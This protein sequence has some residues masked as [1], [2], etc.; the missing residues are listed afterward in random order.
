MNISEAFASVQFPRLEME[1][2]KAF[3]R[4]WGYYANQQTQRT[5]RWIVPLL[6]VLI[7]MMLWLIHCLVPEFGW[8]EILAL[9]IFVV[10]FFF[11]TRQF[12]L[13]QSLA[14]GHDGVCV[15]IHREGVAWD[16]EAMFSLMKWEQ[17]CGVFETEDQLLFIM[18]QARFSAAPKRFFDSE[19]DYM[20]FREAVTEFAEIQPCTANERKQVLRSPAQPEKKSGRIVLIIIWLLLIAILVTWFIAPWRDSLILSEELGE[21][22]YLR[23]QIG[24]PGVD[25]A[26][27]IAVHGYGSGPELMQLLFRRHTDF[28]LTVYFP[29]GPYWHFLGAKWD[30]WNGDD[31]AE[32]AREY[33]HQALRLAL[34]AD[35]VSELHPQAGKPLITGYSQGGSLSYAAA[36]FHPASF[37]AALPIAGA[38]PNEL[39][40]Y[41]TIPSIS[42]RALHGGEDT[43]I[44]YDWAAHTVNVLQEAGWQAD[45]KVFPDMGHRLQA[46]ARQYWAHELQNALY[47]GSEATQKGNS[48]TSTSTA[49]E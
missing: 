29:E 18:D 2:Y 48:E 12:A 16:D 41:E 22:S 21:I 17:L 1:D 34:F 8:I 19:N 20:K 13:R 46:E 33:E 27:I 32:L 38:L 40:E 28:P 9:L 37:S 10:L 31:I 45:L 3:Y 43:V 39:P 35:R 11:I 24:E 42:I 4:V 5:K 36:V 25:I 44:Y 14:L 15:S 30:R 23:V 47:G 6:M 26:P 49:P 7:V